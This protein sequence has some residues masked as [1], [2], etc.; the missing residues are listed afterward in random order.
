MTDE[1]PTAGAAEATAAVANVSVKLPP[2]W[3]SDPEVW[4]ARVE[5]HFA[6]SN[7]LTLRNWGTGNQPNYNMY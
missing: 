3:P 5:A 2:F 7:Y 4:F 1:E 6:Y